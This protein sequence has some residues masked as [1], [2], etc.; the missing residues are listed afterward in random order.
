MT[1]TTKKVIINGLV[2]FDGKL[3]PA[4]I[5]ITAEG[6]IGAISQPGKIEVQEGVQQIDAKG[7]WILPGAIDLHAHLQDGAERFFP[8]SCAAASGGVTTFVDMPPFHVCST[9]EGV[10][11]RIDLAETESVVDFCQGGG[12]VVSLSDLAG[13][14]SLKEIGLPYFKVFMPAEPPVGAG[15]LWKSVNVAARY[16]LRMAI[17]VEEPGCF[18]ESVDWNN[19][20]G[21]ARSRPDVAEVSA[22]AQV[23]EMARAAGAPVHICHVS[24]GKTADLIARYKSQGVD[25]TAETC[26][27]F[28]I[29]EE[30][31]F[32][33]YG[34]RVKTTPPLRKAQDC[35]V[36]WQALNDGVI[37]AVASDHYLSDNPAGYSEPSLEQKEGGIAGIELTFTLLYHTGV[38]EGDLSLDRFV[39]ALA[40][41]PA[42][43]AGIY[44]RKGSISLDKDADLVIFDPEQEWEA[45]PLHRHSRIATVPYQGWKLRGK[46]VSTIV[47]GETVWD[48]Q[49]ICVAKGFGKWIACQNRK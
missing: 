33:T 45:Q 28:L 49:T 9:V 19:P 15:L 29:L 4:D 6:L 8:G 7:N 25:V 22:A 38:R 12:I 48:G 13:I 3:R 36:L 11:E 27:H 42:R 20:L 34:S 41:A 40:I 32:L 37:D 10:R 26:P 31:A 14:A 18:N 5:F 47:R 1:K 43:V 39:H 21:F 24:S 16:G 23:L 44:N 17:H 2:W 35:R 46:V 30:S